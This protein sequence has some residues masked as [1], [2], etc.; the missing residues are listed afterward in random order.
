MKRPRFFHLVGN[1]MW[2]RCDHWRTQLDADAQAVRLASREMIDRAPVSAPAEGGTLDAAVYEQWIE[3]RGGGAAFA[4][5]PDRCHPCVEVFAHPDGD[6]YAARDDG[7]EALL[8]P[9][10]RTPPGANV[11]ASFAGNDFRFARPGA[12]SPDPFGRLWLLER[13][14]GRIRLLAQDDL[15]QLDIV[16]PPVGAELID[17]AAF[18]RGVLAADRAGD[19]LWFQRYGGEWTVL[20]H[21]LPSHTPVAVAGGDFDRCVALLRPLADDA[22]ARFH[23]LVGDGTRAVAFVLGA[24]EAPLPLLMLEEDRVLIGDLDAAPGPRRGVLQF[25]EYLLAGDVPRA[26]RTWG[27][28]GDPTFAGRHDG[29]PG[30]ALFRGC[31]GAPR[32]TTPTGVRAL[33]ELHPE[34]ATEGTV[35]TFALDSRR[36]G[37]V[38]HRVLIDACLPAGTT[39]EVFAKTAEERLPE[40]LRRDPSPDLATLHQAPAAPAA[41]P[42]EADVLSAE[43]RERHWRQLPLG[44]RVRDEMEGWLPVGALDR[45]VGHADI[46]NPPELRRVPSEDSLPRGVAAERLHVDTLEGL[47]KNDPGRFLWLRLILRGAPRRSPAIKA[48]RATYPRPSLLDHLPSFWRASAED[49]RA[50]DHALS[51]FEGLY[52]E[53]DT[54]IDAIRELLDAE[55]CPPEGIEWLATF[56]AVTFDTRVR[57]PVRRQLLLEAAG[58]YR[59]RG[60]LPGMERLCSILAQSRVKIV[61]GFRMRRRTVAYVGDEGWGGHA[62][63]SAVIGP[64]LQ[65]GGH[66]GIPG[67]DVAWEPWEAQL[68]AAHRALLTRRAAQEAPCP[69]QT[70][71]PPFD[72]HPV[73]SF[74]RR[75]AHRFSVLVFRPGDDDLDAVL[76][77]AIEGAKP[78]HTLHRLCWLDA[79]FRLGTNTYV[80]VGTRFA[81]IESYRPG[82]LGHGLLGGI[83]TIGWPRPGELRGARLGLTRPGQ[84]LN[85]G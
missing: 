61:E 1:E 29:T 37:N 49:S 23:L 71:P 74:Y 59:R 57:E 30:W 17:V 9:P 46:A 7:W 82:T 21:G 20:D 80:G 26:H 14:S 47:I 32:M 19:R 28:R 31:D 84:N 25:T 56:L 42:S 77:A 24:L 53:I 15:R 76:Q 45:R 43:T 70:P 65:L 50:M 55:L 36:P 69:A 72:D 12:L 35:E 38:W 85:I 33:Y 39:I 18:R 22:K 60:T 11:F 52:T 41:A 34:L 64:G 78:A 10:R 3:S 58:L 75:F 83:D 8:Q 27:V 62:L 66:D 5:A 48:I 4:C 16:R 44:S 13:D 73:R 81:G 79:G 6:L 2:R 54:R 40:S 51:L 67:A 63:D 68:D